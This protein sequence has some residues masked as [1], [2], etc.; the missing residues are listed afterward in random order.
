M[1][2]PTCPEN[3]SNICCAS[4][5][6]SSGKSFRLPWKH[7]VIPGRNSRFWK[8]RFPFECRPGFVQGSVWEKNSLH[9]RLEIAQATVFSL[10]ENTFLAVILPYH[11]GVWNTLS[12]VQST[13]DIQIAMIWSRGFEVVYSKHEAKN[14][15]GS[16]L[17]KA[18]GTVQL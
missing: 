4:Q 6:A 16:G 9:D 7:P 2:C 8:S 15:S 3:M 1:S 10:R 18:S 13:L 14:R 11:V 12:L 5:R 17:M